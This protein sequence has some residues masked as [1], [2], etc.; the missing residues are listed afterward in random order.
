MFPKDRKSDEDLVKF[1]PA[2]N[3]VS[4]DLKESFLFRELTMTEN[5]WVNISSEESMAKG[6]MTNEEVKRKIMK[7]AEN[8][9]VRRTVEGMKYFEKNAERQGKVFEFKYKN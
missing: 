2:Q 1:Y 6:G 5:I 3:E 9:M 4:Y 8:K 7:H